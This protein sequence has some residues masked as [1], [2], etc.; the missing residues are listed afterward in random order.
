MLDLTDSNLRSPPTIRTRFIALNG[1]SF[2]GARVHR[3]VVSAWTS[4]VF[5]LLEQ[6]QVRAGE[7]K[8]Q[9]VRQPAQKMNDLHRD[10]RSRRDVVLP[11]TVILL[12][13][14]DP[15]SNT[16]RE[17][18]NGINERITKEDRRLGLISLPFSKT[19]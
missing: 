8:Q 18:L 7:E 2:P 13:E 14:T 6:Q 10:Q 15:A 11:V 19:K 3:C 4:F 12:Y 9:D 16:Q 17:D 5:C 1:V